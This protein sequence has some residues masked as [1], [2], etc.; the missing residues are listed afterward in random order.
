MKIS[1]KKVIPDVELPEYATKGSAGFDLKAMRIMALYQGTKKVDL[2]EK[3]NRSI[4]RG[5]IT[6]RPG[7]RALFG[8]GLA[9]TIPYGYEMQ[10]RDKS[11]ISLKR[12]LKVFNAPGTIDSDYRGEVG[13]ILYNSTPYLAEIRLGEYVAQGVIA[14]YKTANFTITEDFQETSRGTGGYGSTGNGL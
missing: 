11:G 13:V 10:I 14:E 12:G 4:E 9:F 7:E 6:L 1:V 5:L 8:T 3:M 2:S